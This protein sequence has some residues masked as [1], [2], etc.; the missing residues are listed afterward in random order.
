[1]IVN[2]HNGVL[3]KAVVNLAEMDLHQEVA[4]FWFRHQMAETNAIQ[5]RNRASVI[6]EFAQV[7]IKQYKYSNIMFDIIRRDSHVNIP[8]TV[9]ML[10]YFREWW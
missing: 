4:K 8:H 9:L 5:L 1:M 6:W 10:L 3:G 7:L 2:S